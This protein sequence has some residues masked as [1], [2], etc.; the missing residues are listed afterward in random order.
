M[1]QFSKYSPYSSSLKLKAYFKFSYE[2]FKPW[3]TELKHESAMFQQF[4]KTPLIYLRIKTNLTR[5]KLI[6]VERWVILVI[7]SVGEKQQVDESD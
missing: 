4:T 3:F 1:L 5:N 2:S 6:I 7:T